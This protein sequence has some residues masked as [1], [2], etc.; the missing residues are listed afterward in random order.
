[1][2]ARLGGHILG[3]KAS[4]LFACI[5]LLFAA[6][7][8][9][10]LAMPGDIIFREM[11]VDDYHGGYGE[12]NRRVNLI[13]WTN[14]K[15]LREENELTLTADIASDLTAHNVRVT[16]RD[17][18]FDYERLCIQSLS[19]I[20]SCAGFQVSDLGASNFSGKR[21]FAFHYRVCSEVD[22]FHQRLSENET[23]ALLAI[24]S[25]NIRRIL[26]ESNQSKMQKRLESCWL[27]EVINIIPEA[28]RFPKGVN[29]TVCA[30]R[31]A[32]DGRIRDIKVAKSSHDLISDARALAFLQKHQPYLPPPTAKTQNTAVLVEF[33]ELNG[34]TVKAG[35][36]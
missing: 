1:M 27:A 9:A 31:L 6:S 18:P 5:S 16:S 7:D 15:S 35:G 17:C 22:R 14:T 29:K 13:Y 33:D 36:N 34:I 32:S 4:V 11:D 3:M 25:A 23:R 26:L 28:D 21:H 12:L 2:I 10:G 30:M 24:H 19:S 20:P 8:G